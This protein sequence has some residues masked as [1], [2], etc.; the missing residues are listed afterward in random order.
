MS[1]A[2]VHFFPLSVYRDHI[3]LDDR[4]RAALAARVEAMRASSDVARPDEQAWSGDVNG[5]ELLHHDRCFDPL[6]AAL[7]AHVDR[8]LG[9]LGLARTSFRCQIVRSWATA[10]GAGQSIAMHR[11]PH[12]HIAA[13]YYLRLPEDGG[14]IGFAHDAPPNQLAPSLFDESMVALGHVH[15][16]NPLNAER[17][18]LTVEQDEL[19]LFPASALH[20]TTPAAAPVTGEDRISVVC[21]I[22]L[23]LRD[24]TNAEHL[25]PD[26]STWRAL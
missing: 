25:L 9:L 10:A 3:D 5:F 2:L 18:F 22:V 1:D 16:R 11:H 12:A 23:T 19:V 8:Y 13:V 24:S 17:A 15:E 6:A 7:P 26:I 20:Y 21:D 14:Q 4:D